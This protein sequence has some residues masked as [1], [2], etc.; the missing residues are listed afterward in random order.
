M[1]FTSIGSCQELAGHQHGD[2][3][4]NLKLELQVFSSFPFPLQRFYEKNEKKFAQETEIN[5]QPV[6]YQCVILISN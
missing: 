3:I 6:N 2:K 1:S 4:I 5:T